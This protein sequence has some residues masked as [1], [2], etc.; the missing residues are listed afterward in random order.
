MY[1]CDTIWHPDWERGSLIDDEMW[2][3]TVAFEWNVRIELIKKL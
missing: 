1:V 2:P 3:S